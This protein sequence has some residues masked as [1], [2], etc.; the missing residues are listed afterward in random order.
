MKLVSGNELAAHVTDM[1][2]SAKQVY[3]D[4][5]HLTA[6]QFLR[7]VSQGRVDFGGG[8]FKEAETEP[9]PLRKLSTD[10]PYGWWTLGPGTYLLRFNETIDLPSRYV[11]FVTPLRR[12]IRSGCFHPTVPVLPEGVALEIPFHVGSKGVEIKEN[13]RLSKLWAYQRV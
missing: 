7:F 2:Y 3:E 10:D 8:E 12:T 4:C 11:A 6:A 1:V 5:L 13:A 9:A